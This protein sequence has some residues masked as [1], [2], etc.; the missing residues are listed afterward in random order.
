LNTPKEDCESLLN[1]VMPLVQQ[2]L[3]Q[4]Q[5]FFPCGAT[6]SPTG[7]IA[8]AMPAGDDKDPNTDVLLSALEEGFR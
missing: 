5:E 7:E 4:Y 3:G 8:L 6:M 2:M 1:A